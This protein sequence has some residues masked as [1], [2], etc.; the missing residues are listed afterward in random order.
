MA[1]DNTNSG[2]L[3]RNDRKTQD[4]HPDYTGSVNVDG[5][6]YWISAWVKEGREGSKMAGRKFFSLSLRAKD[7]QLKPAK[8]REPEPQAGFD[9]DIPF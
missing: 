8:A 2:L 4:A 1:Y 5:R 7:E 6:E 3:A 9:D